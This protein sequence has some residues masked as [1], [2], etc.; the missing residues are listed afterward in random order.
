MPRLV[1]LVPLWG[2][3]LLALG[4][5]STPTST[6]ITKPTLVAVDP[7]DFAGDVPCTDAAGAMRGYVVTL[8]D[9][10]AID[11]PTDPLPLAS[12]VVR[13]DDGRF[14]AT[15]CERTAAFA[16]VI[17]GHR[18]DAEVDAYDRTDLV[19]VGAGSRHLVDAATGEYVPPRWTTTCGRK[20]DGS[21]AEGPV[22]AELYLTRFVRGCKPLV[23]SG[24]DTPTGIS[25]SVDASLGELACGTASG[26]VAS[27]SV[28]Q[29]GSSDPALSADCG[30]SVELTGLEPGQSYWFDVLAF[31]AGASTPR[32]ST[33][34]YRTALKGAL[35]SAACDPLIELAP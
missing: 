14:R 29:Q 18:Y 31:E 11:E 26:E 4:C 12:S 10:G 24:P 28:T 30:K 23:S 5:S 9:L 27:F 19:A 34:C 16:F 21:P 20:T 35:V 13:G 2:L 33:T 22:T 3:P 1:R 25:V 7:A 8:F 17:A 6:G 15:G 32:W